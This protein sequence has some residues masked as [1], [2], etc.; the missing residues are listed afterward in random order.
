[1]TWVSLLVEQWK[2]SEYQNQ[3]RSYCVETEQELREFLIFE[4]L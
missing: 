2:K 4:V 1:M 3:K